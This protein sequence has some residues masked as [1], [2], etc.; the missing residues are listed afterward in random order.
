MGNTTKIYELTCA[1]A[2]EHVEEFAGLVQGAAS[3]LQ[4]PEEEEVDL[5]IAVMEAVNN[6]ILHGNQEDVQKNIRMKIEADPSSMTVWVHDEGGGFV[7]NAVPDP[8]APANVMNTS[9]RGI[10]MM[11]AFM[12]DVEILPTD[13][14]TVVKL[15]KTFSTKSSV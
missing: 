10:L 2:F 7:V 1:S 12:D 5:M 6:A 9:G 3:D 4:L 15:T 8:L 14:G 13:T 11:Q